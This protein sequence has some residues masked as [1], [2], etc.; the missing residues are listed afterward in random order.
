MNMTITTNDCLNSNGFNDT[1]ANVFNSK[2]KWAENTTVS[3]GRLTTSKEGYQVRFVINGFGIK[4]YKDL[5]YGTKE[6]CIC[7]L[8]PLPVPVT[9]TPQLV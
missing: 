8:V 2:N 9:S 5:M 1:I 7:T 3:H 4:E 6:S